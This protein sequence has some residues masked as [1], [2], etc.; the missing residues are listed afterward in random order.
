LNDRASWILEKRRVPRDEAGP[1]V[2]K[3]TNSVSELARCQAVTWRPDR[4]KF[5]IQLAVIVDD[6]LVSKWVKSW[7]CEAPQRGPGRSQKQVDGLEQR[8]LASPFGPRMAV[9]GAKGP[10]HYRQHRRPLTSESGPTTGSF[11]RYPGHPG[12]RGSTRRRRP[13]ACSRRAVW[14]VW[15]CGHS[16]IP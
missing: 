16:S 5:G 11:S 14:S 6:Q 3:P 10:R 7:G 4:M 2:G 13:R 8:R 12:S 1:I 9:D 15:R